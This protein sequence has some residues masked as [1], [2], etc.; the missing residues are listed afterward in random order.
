[1]VTSVTIVSVAQTGQVGCHNLCG[2]TGTIEYF[3][4]AS[5]DFLQDQIVLDV[6]DVQFFVVKR[7]THCWY[8]CLAVAFVT[9]AI[10]FLTYS[11]IKWA[12]LQTSKS[13]ETS[14]ISLLLPKE[15][16]NLQYLVFG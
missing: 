9:Y 3:V 1:V 16:V 6:L 7:R 4:D 12:S 14:R 10:V 8:T 11:L 13:D 2:S 5:S 15:R